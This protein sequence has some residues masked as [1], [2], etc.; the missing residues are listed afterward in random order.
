MQ[1]LPK[2]IPDNIVSNLTSFNDLEAFEPEPQVHIR[3]VYI[4]QTL[5]HGLLPIYWAIR[6][7]GTRFSFL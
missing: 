5:N 3:Q 7:S 6:E 1:T 2:Y 4:L